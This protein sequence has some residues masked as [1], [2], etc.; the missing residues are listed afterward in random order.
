MLDRWR[1]FVH[2]VWNGVFM[3]LFTSSISIQQAR[4]RLSEQGS[5]LGLVTNA[6]IT[7]GHVAVKTARPVRLTS[8][9]ATT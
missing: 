9:P 3:T 8:K 5:V 7:A 2:S 1:L 4:S 6:H